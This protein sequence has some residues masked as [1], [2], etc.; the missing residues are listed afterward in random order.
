[1]SAIEIRELCKSYG[2]RVGVQNVSLSVPPAAIFGFLGPNGAGKTTTI[3]VLL[4]LIR[5]DSGSATVL[6]EDCWSRSTRIKAQVGHL[7]GD[8]RLYPWMNAENAVRLVGKIR[9]LDLTK[10][11]Q[12]LLNAF[13][14]D[15][16]VR[17]KSMSRGMR[18]KL[19]LVLAL[20]HRPAVLILDEPTASLDPL[21]Q[22]RLY[23]ELR[24]LA[25]SGSCV[26]LSSHT[27]DEV[28]RLCERVAI[29]R[30]GQIVANETV[31]GLRARARRM[32]TIRWAGPAPPPPSELLRVLDLVEQHPQTWRGRLCG[33]AV[34]L[35]R[36]CGTQPIADLSIDE[37]D[38][39]T[40][41]QDFYR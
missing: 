19:G 11:A 16:R 30:D 18:Q 20:A 35:A 32:V 4:G 6:G 8:L 7:P 33:S 9:R 34:E 28:E 15:R 23:V 31:E 41:F 39:S 1:V 13:D 36:W 37:P 17:V 2:R 10:E 22:E 5:A 38:L 21:M 26:F 40:L 24:G 27:L 3:R 14:L 12:R 29:I 25:A